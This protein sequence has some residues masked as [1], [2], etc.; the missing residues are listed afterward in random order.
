MYGYESNGYD[1]KSKSFLDN[2]ITGMSESQSMS[3]PDLVPT[4]KNEIDC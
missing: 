2:Q 4:E 3:D 1:Y